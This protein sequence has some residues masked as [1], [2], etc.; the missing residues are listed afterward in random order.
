MCDTVHTASRVDNIL[1]MEAIQVSNNDQ[2]E[3]AN[4]SRAMTSPA[5]QSPMTPEQKR[6]VERERKAAFR[7][8][9]FVEEQRARAF[10]I[11][12]V[13][14]LLIPSLVQRASTRLS[15]ASHRQQLADEAVKQ[16]R[17]V[18]SFCNAR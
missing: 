10:V 8:R 6:V 9:L 7:K 2:A 3:R 12:Y 16:K 5:K 1:R 11:Y 13:M 17:E 18:G 15:V 14:H 4:I